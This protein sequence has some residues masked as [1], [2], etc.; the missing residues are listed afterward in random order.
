M[1]PSRQNTGKLA[2]LEDIANAEQAIRR[3]AIIVDIYC[4]VSTDPQEDNTSLDTQEAEGR[5]FCQEHGFIVGMVHKEVFSGFQYREREELELMRRRYREGKIQGV[6][7]RTFDRLSR[8]Q[9]HFAILLEEMEHHEIEL[10]CVKEQLDDTPIGRFTR[11]VLSFVA[12]M[13]REKIMDRTTTGRINKAKQGRVVAGTKAPYG[14]KWHLDDKGEKEYIEVNEEQA[15]VIR[16]AGKIYADGVATFAIAK[17]LNE[18]KIPTPSE[19]EGI[20]WRPITIR[21]ILADE[22]LTGK[23]APIFHKHSRTSKKQL[24]TIILPEGTYPQ[25]ISEELYKRILARMQTNK[26]EASRKGKDSEEFLLRAGFVRCEECGRPMHAL[27]K[28]DRLRKLK[29]VYRCNR[30]DTTGK[31]VCVGQ[32]IPSKE[33]DEIVWKWLQ[34]LADHI[35]LIEKAIKLATSS[36]KIES[37]TKAIEASIK[38]W[39]QRAKNY[40]AD[41]DDVTLCGESRASIRHSMNHAYAMVERLEN[42]KAQ[43]MIGMIDKEREK[44]AYQDILAWCK[45][46]KE[47]RE[48]LS[49][50]HKRDFLRLLGVV[51]LVQ[52]RIERQGDLL[53]RIQVQLPEVQSL[54]DEK[55]RS[56]EKHPR[57]KMST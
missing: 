55:T 53:Y 34:Q 42:E 1:T 20:E 4:R 30:H 27:S 31:Q 21:R 11:M 24:P 46:V 2:N 40:E 17:Q 29:L 28:R 10:F 38:T 35:D 47:G 26:D 45:K 5:Q 33:L 56:F 36:N 49:Y 51:V 7:I 13:E 16:W 52:K 3:G 50:Q 32:D 22:R 8:S 9:V 14:W 12:E 37:D 44:A 39:R 54:I 43:V 57:W 23:N 6:V 19:Q 15:K 41:L 18:D 48:E 25:I